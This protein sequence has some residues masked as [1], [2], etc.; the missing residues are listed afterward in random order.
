M[1]RR[2]VRKGR[3]QDRNWQSDHP[4]NT[5]IGRTMPIAT[6]EPKG[7]EVGNKRKEWG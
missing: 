7:S 1:K 3:E 6:A 4:C 5:G 2:L